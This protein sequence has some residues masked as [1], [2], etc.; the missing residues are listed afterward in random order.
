MKVKGK[1]GVWIDLDRAVLIGI[2][3][4][5]HTVVTLDSPVEHRVRTEGEGKDFSRFGDQ[6]IDHERSREARREQQIRQYARAV[7]AHLS[8]AEQIVIFGP[9]QMKD[10]LRKTILEQPILASRLKAVESADSMTESQMVAWVR[11]YFTP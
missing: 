9:A 5:T 11:D 2:H 10:W 7:A 4:D 3:G 8:G 1:V 6:Y